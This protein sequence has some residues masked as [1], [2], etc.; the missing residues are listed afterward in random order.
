MSYVALPT[1]RG[2]TNASSPSLPSHPAHLDD[3]GN[4][5]DDPRGDAPGGRRLPDRAQQLVAF[6]NVKAVDTRHQGIVQLGF[7]DSYPSKRGLYP[8]SDGPT[9][10]LPNGV[11]AEITRLHRKQ[12][13]ALPWDIPPIDRA[14]L[15]ACQFR[16]LRSQGCGVINRHA[17]ASLWE[18]LYPDAHALADRLY[19][20]ASRRW[21][22]YAFSP[23]QCLRPAEAALDYTRIPGNEPSEENFRK[24]QSERTGRLPARRGGTDAPIGIGSSSM[25]MPLA[26]RHRTSPGSAPSSGLTWGIPPPPSPAFWRGRN[27]HEP[28]KTGK[29]MLIPPWNLGDIE[30]SVG[31]S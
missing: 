10:P 3:A 11:V 30:S 29:T 16:Q 28:S 22:I 18:D 1:R 31:A 13:T 12:G 15:D 2:R 17:K 26:I 23:R 14:G 27:L 25:P 9:D 21:G 4:L 8:F 7:R 5:T 6:E 19:R 20:Y 24:W